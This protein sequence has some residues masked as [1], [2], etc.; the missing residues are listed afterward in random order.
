MPAQRVRYE[1]EAW[2]CFD[3]AYVDPPAHVVPFYRRH[4][5][6]PRG[7]LFHDRQRCLDAIEA[8]MRW[9]ADQDPLTVCGRPGC[10]PGPMSEWRHGKAELRVTSLEFDRTDSAIVTRSTLEYRRVRT[11]RKPVEV[12]HEGVMVPTTIEVQEEVHGWR[13][14]T[15]LRDEGDEGAEPMVW[16]V[17]VEA[18]AA[19]VRWGDPGP[20]C[21]QKV[22]EVETKEEVDERLERLRAEEVECLRHRAEVSS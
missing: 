20:E 13:P 10:D 8:W 5:M 22:E 14:V 18:S 17:E 1:Q 7:V 21:E 12:E 9:I 2:T 6:D 19:P 4:P 16:T 15:E 11:V 3:W